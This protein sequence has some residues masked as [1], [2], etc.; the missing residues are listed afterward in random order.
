MDSGNANK[1]NG[2]YSQ[3]TGRDGSTAL[4]PVFFPSQNVYPT[5]VGG[6][7]WVHTFSPTIVNE[8]RFGFTRVRWDNSIPTD[9]SGNFGLTGNAKVGIPFIGAQLYP[10]FSGQSISNNASYI[11]T[12]A[13]TQILRDNTFNYYDNLTWQRGRHFLSIGGK[14]RD[15]SRTTLMLPTS[16]SWGR[17]PTPAF[18]PATRM[19]PMA[20]ATARQTSF[21]IG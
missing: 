6:A 19:P 7:S 3:G 11:G 1:I 9:P 8:A 17:F 18:S 10:G 13:N 12:N 20:R 21:W 5:H 16:D 2:F 14:Q 15:T 4:I